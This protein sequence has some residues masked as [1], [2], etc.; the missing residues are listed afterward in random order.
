MRGK[1]TNC[2]HKILCYQLTYWLVVVL[3]S[4]SWQCFKRAQWK[5]IVDDYSL[6]TFVSSEA[7][8]LFIEFNAWSTTYI[9]YTFM[10]NVHIWF[11]G[12]CH[13]RPLQHSSLHFHF[14]VIQALRIIPKK[15]M[16]WCADFWMQANYNKQISQVI[17]NPFT[18]EIFIWTD[19]K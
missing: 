9:Q 15:N 8:D 12:L 2:F 5:E 6:L 17:S 11:D 19:N 13:S 4:V 16:N 3:F 7:N 10:L 14:T 18:L 1:R